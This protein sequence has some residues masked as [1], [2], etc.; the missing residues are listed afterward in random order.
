M[1]YQEKDKERI[2]LLH[3]VEFGAVKREIDQATRTLND[4]RQSLLVLENDAKGLQS[5]YT[6]LSKTLQDLLDKIGK[7]NKTTPKDEGE[8]QKA[9]TAISEMLSKLDAIE[10]QLETVSK[11]IAAKTKLFKDKWDAAA[12]AQFTYKNLTP[13]YEEQIAKI[14]PQLDKIEAELA[15]IAKTID[16]ALLDKYKSRRKNEQTDKDIVVKTTD[17]RCG[18]CYFEMPLSLIHKI[19]T[20]G[21]IVCEECGRIIYKG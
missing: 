12:R 13:K 3:T 1:D 16:K 21:Y 14:K 20:N 11:S 4:A 19:S 18:G 7:L 17:G 9:T 6:A 5:S 8:I 15:V 2:V 10:G